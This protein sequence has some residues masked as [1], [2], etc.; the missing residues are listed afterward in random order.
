MTVGVAGVLL[1]TAWTP[2]F[3]TADQ[4]LIEQLKEIFGNLEDKLEGVTG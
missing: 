2:G 3:V 1:L 4:S